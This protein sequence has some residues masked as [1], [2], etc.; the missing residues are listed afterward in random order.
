MKT[1]KR[2]VIGLV[3]IL[4]VLIAFAYV[5]PRHAAVVRSID[6]AATPSAVYPIVSDLRRFNE[7]S[8]WRDLDSATVYIFTGPADGVGQTMNW[9]SKD[10]RVGTGKQSITRLDPLKEVEMNLDFGAQGGA[11]ARIALA[12]NGGATTVTWGF[13]SDL[14]FNP[15]ARY[16][17]LFFERWIGPDYE[18]GLAKLKA[19]AEKPAASG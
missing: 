11:I 19:L 5:L 14:G 6:V 2:I 16:F 9:T 8:P 3:A 15:L 10:P 13:D 17:G 18:K 4:V 7:W 1:V 12:P